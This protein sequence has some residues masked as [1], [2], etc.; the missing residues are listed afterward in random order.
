[1]TTNIGQLA[2]VGTPRKL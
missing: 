2:K 1:M